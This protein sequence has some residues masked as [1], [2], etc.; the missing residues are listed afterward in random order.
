MVYHV[1]SYSH[2]LIRDGQ[3]RARH[4]SVKDGALSSHCIRAP[5]C[6]QK[7]D[8]STHIPSPAHLVPHAQVSF[9]RAVSLAQHKAEPYQISLRSLWEDDKLSTCMS[10]KHK[11]NKH[12]SF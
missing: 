1:I 9:Q 8:H 6:E 4:S 11:I 5:P 7:P 12:L 2:V 3:D 10:V